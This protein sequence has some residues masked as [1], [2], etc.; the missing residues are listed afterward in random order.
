MRC[1]DRFALELGV[2]V[3]KYS[4]T[5]K[6]IRDFQEIWGN[7]KIMID[8]IV[9]I[10]VKISKQKK[11]ESYFNQIREFKEIRDFLLIE[12]THARRNTSK[13]L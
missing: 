12:L 5:S 11:Y 6:N 4:K 13:T 8:I 9:E 2:W 10:R 3:R 1:G 7:N